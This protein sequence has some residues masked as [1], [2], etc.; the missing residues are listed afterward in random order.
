M[1][2]TELTSQS[3]MGWLKAKAAYI[4]ARDGRPCGV[5]SDVGA[6]GWGTDDDNMA[7]TWRRKSSSTRD[8]GTR[9]PNMPAMVVTELT[10][11]S[12]IG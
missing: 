9:T 4:A 7:T 1:S 12:P 2:V 3:P 10:S 6:R 8:R 5:I 11:Q